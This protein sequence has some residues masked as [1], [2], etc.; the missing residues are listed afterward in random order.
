M[1]KLCSLLLCLALVLSMAACGSQTPAAAPETQAPTAAS[2]EATEVSQPASVET[3]ETKTTPVMP[4]VVGLDRGYIMGYED[5]GTYIFKGIPYGTH[6]RFKYATPVESY[7][8]ADAPTGV[9]TNG[10]VCPQINTRTEY[11]SYFASAAFMTPSDSDLFSTES[12][13]LNLNV[14]TTNLDE[15]AKK[16]VLVFMHGGGRATGSSIELKTYNGQY[17]AE[18]TD[19][20]FVSVNMR[21]NYL[22][23]LDLTAL[24]GDSNIAIADMVLSLEWVRDN[25]AKFGGDPDNVTIVGQSGGGG[26]VTSLASAPAAQGLFSKAVVISG[27]ATTGR[28]PEEQAQSAYEVADYI[29]GNVPEMENATNE[30]VFSYLQT[31]RY[32]VIYDLLEDAGAYYY[33]TSGNEYFE[34]DWYNAETGRLNDI[35]SQYTYMIGS[36]WAE[37]GGPNS[38]DSI[39]TSTPGNA[40]GNISVEAQEQSVKDMYGDDYAAVKELFET[41]YPNH[42]IYDLRSLRPVGSTYSL[43]EYAATSATVYHYLVAYTMP[44]FGGMTMIHTGDVPFW[45]HSLETVPQ[46]S[47][48][49]EAAANKVA[50][51]M[52]SALAAFCATGDPSTATLSWQAHTE[53]QPMTM[54][55]DTESVC[56]D[57]TYDDEL[58][59]MI[60]AH[61]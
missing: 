39:L 21:L 45:F 54:V 11:S 52:A 25:I 19:V 43:V 5:N 32:D 40:K 20:V 23:Y 12:D 33:V 26:K 35:A 50:D 29:R 37:A 59:A 44:Y 57:G 58:Q 42:D 34:S 24:G 56:K 8:T 60:Q 7:G 61:S 6:E 28:S 15:K 13:C 27:T 55:F 47:Y 38:A 2:T 53:S 36:A 22:G 3:V 48:G 14:W 49:D 4:A 18:Y 41:A 16:P 9:L 46:L 31:E 17:F 51:A 10:P 1:K 30:E